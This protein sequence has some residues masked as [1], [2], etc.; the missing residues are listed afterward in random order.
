LKKWHAYRHLMFLRGYSF[1]IKG[2]AWTLK[3]SFIDLIQKHLSLKIIEIQA[4]VTEI[5]SNTKDIYVIF[6]F[7]KM[8]NDFICYISTEKL[9]L[10]TLAIKTVIFT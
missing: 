8:R 6:F 4:L 10:T 5:F 2:K 1:L 3:S 9:I 7:L